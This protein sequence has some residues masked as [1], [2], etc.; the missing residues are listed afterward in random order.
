MEH[1]GAI[2]DFGK[3]VLHI[4]ADMVWV[5]KALSW[6]VIVATASGALKSVAMFFQAVRGK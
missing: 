4:P 2:V 3:T 6:C 1:G 5:A